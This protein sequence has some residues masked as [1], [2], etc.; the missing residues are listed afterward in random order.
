MAT[1]SLSIQCQLEIC[2]LLRLFG[3]ALRNPLG[4]DQIVEP[5]HFALAGLQPQLVQ[6]AGVAVK[7]T[8]GPRDGFT[9]TLPAL[10]HLAAAAL[11]DPHPGLCRGAVEEGEMNTEAVVGVIL[12]TGV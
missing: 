10:L 2:L 4:C 3:A 5:L 1:F 8:A 9:Q 12:R 7:R 11:Q 6:L